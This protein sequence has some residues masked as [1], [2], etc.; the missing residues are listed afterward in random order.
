ML[1][2]WYTSEPHLHP[3]FCIFDKGL[4]TPLKTSR[5]KKWGKHMVIRREEGNSESSESALSLM[6]FYNPAL[7]WCRTGPFGAPAA[8]TPSSSECQLLLK[9]L[10][11]M[12]VEKW[13]PR[14]RECA[15]HKAHEPANL[16]T[17]VCTHCLCGGVGLMHS[18]KGPIPVTGSR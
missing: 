1:S 15:T 16:C 13:S 7:D 11:M 14:G 18:L 17:G 3:C 12:R 10:R 2:K 9:V 6:C 4:L 8:T 5:G